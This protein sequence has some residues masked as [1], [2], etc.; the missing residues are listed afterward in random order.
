MKRVYVVFVVALAVLLVAPA[1]AKAFDCTNRFA[2]ARAAIGRITKAMKAVHGKMSSGKIAQV[3]MLLDDAKMLLH[4]GKHN[5][6]NPQGPLDHA[7][8]I[9]KATSA[10]GHAEAAEKLLQFYNK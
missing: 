2:A 5:H 6:A 7:R 10:L 1:A 3:H 4:G 8:A 9:A